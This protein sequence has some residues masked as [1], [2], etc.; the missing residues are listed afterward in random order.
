MNVLTEFLDSYLTSVKANK[1]EFISKSRKRNLNDLRIIYCAVARLE[2]NFGL[3]EIGDTINRDHATV[4][5]A[6]KNYNALSDVDR[7]FKEDY[8]KAKHIFRLI[9]PDHSWPE[10]IHCIIDTMCLS[11][12]KLRKLIAI[13]DARISI[14]EDEILSLK[15]KINNYKLEFD[16]NN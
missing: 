4:I 11:N 16:G 2:G 9:N 10:H 6:V 15:N 3:K 8:S 5:H 14:N 13:K 7:K 1:D 12:N